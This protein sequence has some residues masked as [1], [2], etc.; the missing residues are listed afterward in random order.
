MESRV[1]VPVLIASL[2]GILAGGGGVLLAGKARTNKHDAAIEAAQA[3]QVEA[4]SKAGAEAVEAALAPALVEVRGLAELARAVP[5]F[6]QEGERYSESACM[7]YWTCTRAGLGSGEAVGCDR[8]VNT[9]E[10][11]RQIHVI[12]AGG[13]D[14]ALRADRRRDF[15]KRK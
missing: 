8:A 12:E 2:A 9:W 15:E 11:E 5:P 6:C 10:G 7:A 4:A 1:L 14:A 3:Q 13:A